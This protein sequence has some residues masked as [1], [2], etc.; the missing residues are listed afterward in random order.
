[1]HRLIPSTFVVALALAVVGDAGTECQGSAFHRTVVLHCDGLV[2]HDGPLEDGVRIK[3][4]RR[5]YLPEDVL[6]ICAAGQ[7]HVNPAPHP[8]ILR[9]L[10]DPHVIWPAREGDVGSRYVTRERSGTGIVVMSICKGRGHE[11][12]GRWDLFTPR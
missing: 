12:E 6:R 10:K 11:H 7:D 1:M 3:N 4:R 2:R 8:K 5:A 9:T